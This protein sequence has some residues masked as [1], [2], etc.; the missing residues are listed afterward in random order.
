MAFCHIFCVVYVLKFGQ[1]SKHFS[2]EYKH[3]SYNIE[4]VLFKLAYYV[5]LVYT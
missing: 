3:L 2:E 1:C 4:N 5:C